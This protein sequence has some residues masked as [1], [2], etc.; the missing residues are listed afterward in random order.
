M[1]S[2]LQ[3]HGMNKS[4]WVEVSTQVLANH[5]YMDLILGIVML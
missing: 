2:I 1:L 3:R 4:V 5:V